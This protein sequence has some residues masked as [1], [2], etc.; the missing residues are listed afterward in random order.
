MIPTRLLPALFGL[1]FAVAAETLPPLT[2]SEVPM[3]VEALHASFDPAKEPLEVTVVKEHEQ[4]GIVVRRLTYV[5]GTF[6]GRK[7]VMGAFYAFPKTREGKLP[8]ILQM[9]GGGQT[10][11][12]ETVVAWAKNGYAAIAINW[13]G[14]PMAGQ[15]PGEPGT[16]WGAVDATQTGHNS[17]YAS[18]L[19]DG[20]TL[21]PFES[22]RNNNWF[23]ITL[24]ARRAV[25]FL[26]QQPEVDSARIGATGHS[27]GGTL[28]VM[29]AGCDPRIKAA[30]PSCGG[31]GEAPDRLR[32]RPGNAARPKNPSRIHAA[33]IDETNYLRRITCPIVYLGPQNDFN[34]LIDELFMN[35]E[36]V[37]SKQVAFAISKHH[38]HRHD[39]GAS[40]VDALWF[41]QHLKGTLT[42]PRTPDIE[43]VLKGPQGEPLV[44]VR[45]DPAHPVEKVEI[46]YSCDPNG[47]FRFWRGAEVRQDGGAW[48]AACPVFSAELPLYFIANVHYQFP[49]PGLAGP[50][51]HP[52]P[53]DYYFLSSRMLSFEASVVKAAAPAA[54]DRH[55][56]RIEAV[57]GALGDWYELQRGNPEFRQM[58]TRKTK[59]P[60]W[61]GP[62]G[63]TLAIDVRDP[64]GGALALGFEFNSYRQYGAERV[65]GEF[66]AELPFPASPEWRTLEL[67][68]SDLIPL[69][70]KSA[71]PENWQTLCALSISARL[72]AG[73]PGAGKT[74]GAGRFDQER[75][76]RN[77]RWVGG[78]VPDRL[79]MPGGDVLD[80]AARA[81]EF[82]QQIDRSIE[83][84]QR[85]GQK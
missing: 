49:V 5:V 9:H 83:L 77:L 31:V 59:D 15:L 80:P 63:A 84:E 8:G 19:P 13:G 32:A 23:L 45:P 21:D 74:L 71:L 48:T 4:D 30:A 55:E 41:E 67:K 3:S 12:A 56:R 85:D 81:R 16:D 22:P 43:A 76:L 52:R 64:R 66:A 18:C 28:T 40:F 57:F 60:K 35:W 69:D 44:T 24:A 10:A 42:L 20:K 46:L 70:G 26:Q 65:S 25:T 2:E 17:H 11:Q 47:Q 6:K 75:Q 53:A 68:L 79:L 61:R 14:K 37:P 7:S 39:P 58:V 38:N 36:A 34:G 62:D 50:P 51:W 1:S 73:P 29:L 54:T 82:Q 33:T 27:M 78:T 72:K